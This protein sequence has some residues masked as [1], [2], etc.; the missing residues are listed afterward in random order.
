MAEVI[1]KPQPKPTVL[2]TVRV[3]APIKDEYAK[4][5]KAADRQS[6]DLT[7][8]M[9]TALSDVFK[10]VMGAAPA[11]VSSLSDRRGSE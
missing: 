11:K 10:A 5:R 6:I 8:M 1:H 3:E 4:A 2:L 9:S 7:S